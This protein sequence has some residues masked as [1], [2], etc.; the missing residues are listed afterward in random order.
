[1][2]ESDECEDTAQHHHEENGEETG[3]GKARRRVVRL[4]TV[5]AESVVSVA[6]HGDVAFRITADALSQGKY[7]RKESTQTFSDEERR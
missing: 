3:R 6:I 4:L 5:S 7:A 1:M 2:I